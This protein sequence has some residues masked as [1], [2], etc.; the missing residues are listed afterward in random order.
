MH[1][2]YTDVRALFNSIFKKKIS[3]RVMVTC[4]KCTRAFIVK[5]G[6]VRLSACPRARLAGMYACA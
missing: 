1:Y 4:R 2:T 3:P 6:S 5:G